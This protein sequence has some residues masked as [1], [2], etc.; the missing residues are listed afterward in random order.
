MTPLQARAAFDQ[1]EGTLTTRI[2]DDRRGAVRSVRAARGVA[3]FSRRGISLRRARTG[4]VGDRAASSPDRSRCSRDARRGRLM[5]EGAQ[6]VIVGRPNAGKS[7]L[8]NALAG[9]GRAIV[10]D[11]PG[12]TRDLLTEVVDIDGVPVTLV[13]TA[14]L[15]AAAGR[16]RRDTKASRARARRG[17]SPTSLIVVLDRSRPLDRRR[18]RVAARRRRHGARVVVA[19]K[20]DL[21]RGVERCRTVEAG[22]AGVGRRRATASTSCATRSSARCRL[23]RTAARYAGDHERPPRRAARRA[24]ARALRARGR[25]RR[26]DVARGIRRRGRAAR[27]GRCSRRSPAREPRTTCCTRSST[28][29]CIGK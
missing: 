26:A 17:A 7:S 19:N 24:R 3:R 5:R 15:R 2:R 1:L 28:R 12:T 4:R 10:T 13:D 27:R 11:I 9:A 18:S 20:S 23:T 6:V 21:P 25:P 22:A 16:R 14:G 29:F 8:F